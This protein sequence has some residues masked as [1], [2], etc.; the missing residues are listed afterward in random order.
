MMAYRVRP[1]VEFARRDAVPTDT[2]ETEPSILH[3][4]IR[5]R[6]AGAGR[7]RPESDQPPS[8]HARPEQDRFA[9]TLRRARPRQPSTGILNRHGPAPG[10]PPT[11]KCRREADNPAGQAGRRLPRLA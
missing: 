8:R 11:A 9:S 5:I 4:L 1:M 7:I 6:S 2:E 3:A 10:G